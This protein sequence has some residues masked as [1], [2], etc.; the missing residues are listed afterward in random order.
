MEYLVID[1]TATDDQDA[2]EL[3]EARVRQYV[4]LGWQPCGGIAAVR[5]ERAAEA[6]DDEPCTQLFQAITHPDAA[7]PLP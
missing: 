1:V 5:C 6:F 3:L 4:A 7:A 2:A